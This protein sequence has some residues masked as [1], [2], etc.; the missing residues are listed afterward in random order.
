MPPRSIVHPGQPTPER[1]RVVGC[2]AHRVTLTVK[3][4]VSVNEAIA[5]AFAEQGFEGGYVRLANVAMKRLDYVMPAASPD[6]DHAAW[7][8]ATH[9]VPVATIV[10]AGLHM[11]RR[12]G[13]PFL[14][15]HGSWKG[16]NGAF[17]MG[18]LLPFD[19]EF[20]AETRL[21]ALAL[22]GAILDVQPDEETNFSLFSPVRQPPRRQD[23]GLR[24]L[25]CTIRPNMDICKAIEAVCRQFG[26]SEA[27]VHGIGSLIGAD[28]DDGTTITAY[29][30]EVLIRDG[31]VHARLNGEQAE[32]DI[33]MV[34]LTGRIS[35]GKLVRGKNPVCVTAEVLLTENYEAAG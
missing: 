32:L 13:K 1:F 25:L 4:G 28:Y 3:P 34:D 33:A 14:H 26:L 5:A 12:D 27:S 10:E 19:A 17:G 31:R 9:T 21:G 7:Y 35:G 15:C 8:S 22:D 23:G 6:D 2:R 20:A 29:A 24:A 16:E 18:H 11:G 30:T